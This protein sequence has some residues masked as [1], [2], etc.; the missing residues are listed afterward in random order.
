MTYITVSSRLVI[1]LFQATVGKCTTS[2]PG[3]MDFVGR[4]KW[5]S[6]NNLENMNKVL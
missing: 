6:W 2:R 1:L 3:M 5:D 4:A